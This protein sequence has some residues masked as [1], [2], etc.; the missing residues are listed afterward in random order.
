MFH[1]LCANRLSLNVAKTE[2]IVFRPPKRSLNQIIILKLNGTKIYESLKIKYLG[3]LLDPYLRWNHHINELT[4]KLNCAIGMIYKIRND[5][6]Q[7]VLVSLYYSLFHSHLSYCLSIWGTSNDV[8][9]SKLTVLQ[10]KII[11]SI[12]LS[13]FNAHS[14]PLMKRIKILKVKDLY[15]QKI[16]S[17]M[18][19]FDHN[20]LPLSLSILFTRRNEIHNRN[21][22]DQKN[23]KLYTAHRFNNRHGY[24][25]FAHYG[26]S[27][28]NK[29]KELPFYENCSSKAVFHN[30]YKRY[31]LDTY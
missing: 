11:R 6:T 13:D 24:D 15:N 1:W 14:S 30:K 16:M 17:L 31:I 28:L 3:V 27:L 5:C 19:D 2:F 18:W 20:K 7:Q 25:S 9:L 22:R 4:K 29:V 23:N 12:T 21:L 26:A 8:Y 10:K